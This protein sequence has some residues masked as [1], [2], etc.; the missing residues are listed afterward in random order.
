MNPIFSFQPFDGKSVN[1]IDCKLLNENYFLLVLGSELG[2]IR[3][4]KF[5][6]KYENTSLIISVEWHYEIPS[7][8]SHGTSVSK[9]QIK[10][11]TDISSMMF[12]SCGE[13]HTVRV[14]QTRII[15]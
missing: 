14:H 12:A 1:S 6:Q 13:D 7:K 9:I 10:N 5:S 3:I 2:S 15:G 8:F 11:E 4:V